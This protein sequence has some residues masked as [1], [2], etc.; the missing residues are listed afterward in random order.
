[1][2]EF[3]YDVVLSFAGED[4]EY[5]EAVAL[6]LRKNNIRVFYDRFEEANLWG[7]NLYSEFS[8]VYST[9]SRYCMIF[10]S[11]HYVKK[12]WTN[13][14]LGAIQE[15]SF[16]Q[17][18][19]YTLP[20]RFD[21]SVLI[22]LKRTIGYIDARSNSPSQLVNIFLEKL[23]R[24]MAVNSDAVILRF[25][26]HNKID[27]KDFHESFDNFRA[28]SSV[29]LRLLPINVIFPFY[30]E[31]RIDTYRKTIENIPVSENISKEAIQ[32][33]K[34]VYSNE[35]LNNNFIDKLISG[36]RLL[37]SMYLQQILTK[38]EFETSLQIYS[39]GK[40]ISLIR[41]FLDSRIINT[42]DEDWLKE[43][44][45]FRPCYSAKAMDALPWV[46]KQFEQK[47][48]LF[49][50][51]FDLD[52]RHISISHLL[53]IPDNVIIDNANEYERPFLQRID[54]IKYVLPQLIDLVGRIDIDE[55]K[56]TYL[57]RD[58]NE[59]DIRLREEKY[60]RTDNFEYVGYTWDERIKLRK[61]F[62]AKVEQEFDESE[63]DIIKSKFDLRLY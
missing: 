12:D 24:R 33:V 1:M 42:I 59:I 55:Y 20:V 56:I 14:E 21:D 39:S 44:Y 40:L 48:V 53:Y 4:R 38:D 15:R 46:I 10:V 16:T 30:I 50:V 25:D 41:N 6:L 13:L 57:L 23:G 29:N 47:Q 45:F 8:V 27:F 31:Q 62:I 9:K 34:N 18:D 17:R 36:T 37:C 7:K 49:W 28:W 61:D 43:F 22:G 11:K 35:Y 2:I 5:V 19:E 52:S 63:A 58:V 51:A 54:F 60:Y 26:N 32:Q 3:E